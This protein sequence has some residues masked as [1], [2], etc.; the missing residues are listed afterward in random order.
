MAVFA[1]A[2]AMVGQTWAQAHLSATR[3]A[4]IMSME[5]VFAALFAVLA[6]RRGP[7]RAAAGRRRDGAGRDADR[8]AAPAPQ[9]R[10]RGH[11]HRG[12]I[13]DR[14]LPV[15]QVRADSPSVRPESTVVA[16]ES[17]EGPHGRRHVPGRHRRAVAHVV[18]RVESV[19]GE[20]FVSKGVVR[21]IIGL[22]GDI[23]SFHHLNL[24]TLPGR[25]RRA[26]DL[27]PLQAG[28]PPAPP[29]AVHGLGRPGR[30]RRCRSARTR[31]RSSPARARSRR[32]SRRRGG[33][34]GAV[35][36]RHDPARRRV[37]AAHLAVRLPGA[38]RRR[39]SRSWP[40]SARRTGMPVVTEVVDARDVADRRGV[41]RHAPGRHPQH[42]QLRAAPGGRRV[43]QAGAAQARA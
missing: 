6:R 22:V 29:R 15:E 41:R 16:E 42:G 27:R 13:S 26:P 31:S 40:T 2:L 39:A 33:A 25:R 36:R 10:G 28:Q 9:D 37:Q 11:P 5:P 38:G 20:A 34:D 4:I 8:R 19:G 18:E 3:C 43:R 1:G 14:C 17:T 21:T 32:R 12:L 35:R 24:R 23:D 30:A 7:H